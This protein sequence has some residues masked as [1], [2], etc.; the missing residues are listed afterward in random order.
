MRLGFIVPTSLESI[1]LNPLNAHVTSAGYGAGK[2]A[3][4]AAAADLIFKK[5]CDT[6]IIWGLAGSLNPAVG[7][8]D[9]LIGTAAAYHDYN[10]AP[11]AGSTGVGFVQ[12]F[13]ENIWV[14]LDPVLAET[15]FRSVKEL[16]PGRKVVKGRICTGDQFV[17][18]E[19]SA[20]YNRVEKES[21]AVDMESAA[22]VHFCHLVDKN[23]KVGIVRIISDNADHNAN[24]NFSEFLEEFGKLNGK[25]YVFREK[26]LGEN[27]TL[28]RLAPYA[29]NA[30]A[31]VAE[32][33]LFDE[34]C[35]KMYDRFLVEE[36]SADIDAVISGD[37]ESGYFAKRIAE[38]LSVPFL[39]PVPR[40]GLEGK[41][42]LPV[43][44]TLSQTS[45]VLEKRNTFTAKGAEA[46][47]ILAFSCSRKSAE[48]EEWKK[49]KIKLTFLV[50]E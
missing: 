41:K 18:H 28:E 3:V 2:T 10:I 8:N 33:T 16:F 47:H 11:L 17:Q 1:N 43:F 12:D 23:V 49:E 31:L 13:A 14:E 9:I 20:D 32:K 26:I 44:D 40:E 37:G 24:I 50:E 25:M 19:S 35:H 48:A 22:L 29:G 36:H 45:S 34:A 4:C 15:L 21:Y 5:H 6:I 42:L 46:N 30:A 7:V 38:M 39:H 27:S